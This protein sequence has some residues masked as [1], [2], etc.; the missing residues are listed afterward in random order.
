MQIDPHFSPC[1]KLKS[2]W[3]KDLNIK[4]HPL[5]LIN[6]KVRNSIEHV[7]TGANFQSRKPIPQALVSIINKWDFIKQKSFNAKISNL[8]MGY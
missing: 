8:K 6:E 1:T 7:E 3:I 2:K 5:N 4:P